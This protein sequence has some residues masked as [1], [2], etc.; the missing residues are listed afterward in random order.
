[1]LGE[2]LPA[3]LEFSDGTE[4]ALLAAVISQDPATLATFPLAPAYILYMATRCVDTCVNH[5]C[6]DGSLI[7]SSDD[8]LEAVATNCFAGSGL[9]PST[10]PS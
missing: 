5:C 3:V 4:D 10:G 8:N 1:M 2:V 7:F 6:L 9:A